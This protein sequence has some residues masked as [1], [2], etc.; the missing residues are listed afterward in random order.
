MIRRVVSKMIV[1]PDADLSKLGKP[2]P[3]KEFRYQLQQLF[4]VVVYDV[5]T[6]KK[7][8]VHVFYKH[9]VEV[10]DLS[11]LDL[12]AYGYDEIPRG[13]AHNMP[14]VDSVMEKIDKSK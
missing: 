2:N 5:R 10:A 13:S 1:T 3:N 8:G 9:H 6:R 14:V 7:D 11:E 4:D 12:R